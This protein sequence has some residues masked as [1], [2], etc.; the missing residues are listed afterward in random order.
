MNRFAGIQSTCAGFILVLIIC[1]MAC[2]PSENISPPKPSAPAVAPS[3]PAASVQDAH[4]L[5]NLQQTGVNP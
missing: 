5:P 3:T 2:F 1:A 4:K